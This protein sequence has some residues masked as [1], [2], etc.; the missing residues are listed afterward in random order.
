MWDP[1]FGSFAAAKGFAG[2]TESV[3][4]CFA[5]RPELVELKATVVAGRQGEAVAG[6]GA[7][8]AAVGSDFTGLLQKEDSFATL[9]SAFPAAT[10]KQSWN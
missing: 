10:G 5:V 7:R 4:A 8:A 9:P 1:K 6:V 3:G 2:L